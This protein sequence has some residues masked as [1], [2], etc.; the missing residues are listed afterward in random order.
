LTRKNVLGIPGKEWEEKD[1]NQESETA[2][3]LPLT[4]KH[5]DHARSRQE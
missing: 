3:N 4:S 2:P 5:D 1:E